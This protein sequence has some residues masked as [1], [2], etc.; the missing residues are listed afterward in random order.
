[1]YKAFNS[2]SSLRMRL[3]LWYTKWSTILIRQERRLGTPDA[4]YLKTGRLVQDHR[5]GGVEETLGSCPWG[6]GEE[7][8]KTES[9]PVLMKDAIWNLV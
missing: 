7:E 6:E 2:G 5:F 9:H 1:M 4:I 8:T 3:K